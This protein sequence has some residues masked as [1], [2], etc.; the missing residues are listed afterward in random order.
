MILNPVEIRLSLLRSGLDVRSERLAYPT[1][2]SVLRKTGT[3]PSR[4]DSGSQG[5]GSAENFTL[6]I[7]IS[8]WPEIG[9]TARDVIFSASNYSSKARDDWR[10]AQGGQPEKAVQLVI[11]R[12][13][14]S[15]VASTKHVTLTDVLPE[16]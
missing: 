10:V 7:D 6:N 13:N 3:I 4:A 11:D 8:Q 15:I 1:K 14:G 2:E 16:T 9:R 5:K 12:E